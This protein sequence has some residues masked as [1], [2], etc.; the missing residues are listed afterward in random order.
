MQDADSLD[1]LGDGDDLASTR[2]GL[3][4]RF[5]IQVHTL[6]FSSLRAEGV[7]PVHMG[8]LEV[9]SG[10][11]SVADAARPPRRLCTALP[12]AKYTLTGFLDEDGCLGVVAVQLDPLLRDPTCWRLAEIDEPDTRFRCE[13]PIDSGHLVI[14]DTRDTLTVHD[15]LRGRLQGLVDDSR[16]LGGVYPYCELSG[17]LGVQGWVFRIE[18]LKDRSICKSTGPMVFPV[19][20]GGVE[21]V[22]DQPQ[23]LIQVVPELR[24]KA[25]H[26]R[27]HSPEL[28]RVPVGV[29]QYARAALLVPVAFPHA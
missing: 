7:T 23:D 29:T 12:R 5:P 1:T 9:S 19:D 4:D 27:Q 15:R 14:C 26:G 22:P 21:K 11:V 8:T 20:R 17:P 18:D 16:I 13:V 2:W 10:A 28:P 3:G 25:L 6:P 24:G